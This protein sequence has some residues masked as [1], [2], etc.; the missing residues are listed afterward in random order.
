MKVW[1]QRDRLYRNRGELSEEEQAMVFAW[2]RTEVEA[3][4]AHVRGAANSMLQNWTP[5]MRWER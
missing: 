2:R 3:L 5:P 1:E 4:P